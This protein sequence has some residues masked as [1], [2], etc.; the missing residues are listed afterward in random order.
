MSDSSHLGHKKKIP[1]HNI[2]SCFFFLL[3]RTNLWISSKEKS[4]AVRQ[5]LEVSSTGMVR[6][7]WKWSLCSLYTWPGNPESRLC[8]PITNWAYWEWSLCS[9]YTWPGDPE[10][11]LCSP[12]NLLDMLEAASMQPLYYILLGILRVVSMWPYNGIYAPLL[13]I[14][15]YIY[16]LLETQPSAD[17]GFQVLQ[18]V[19]HHIQPNRHVCHSPP[20][21]V[22]PALIDPL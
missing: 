18:L 12:H 3:S 9:L 14:T 16:L 7:S 15:S 5:V 10:S 17:K 8:A 11:V 19:K 13:V 2:Q 1:T 20:N 21:K 6:A 4:L 22:W